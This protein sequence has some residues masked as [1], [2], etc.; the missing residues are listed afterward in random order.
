[1]A[2]RKRGISQRQLTRDST[3]GRSPLRSGRG[4]RFGG[5]A[6]EII[7]IV[8][9]GF[10]NLSELGPPFE[11]LHGALAQRLFRSS[12]VQVRTARVCD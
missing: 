6:T 7:G 9:H 8:G 5:P 10:R 2:P 12:H 1:M 4:A 3:F 11:R